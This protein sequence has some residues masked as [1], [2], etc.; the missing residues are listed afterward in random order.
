MYG[1]AAQ[2]FALLANIVNKLGVRLNQLSEE[3]GL[4]KG[5]TAR[6]VRQ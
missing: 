2:K 5:A 6:C 4:N 1:N 3:F